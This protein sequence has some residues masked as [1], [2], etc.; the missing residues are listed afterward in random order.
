MEP[1]AAKPEPALMQD[2]SLVSLEA[3]LQQ[4]AA[5]EYDAL[6]GVKDKPTD[7]KPLR[8]FLS[9]SSPE[10]EICQH[11]YKALKARGHDPWFDKTS[12]R[13]GRDWRGAIAQGVQDSQ[14]V[15]ACLSEH[16]TRDDEDGHS[17]CLD[18]LAIAAGVKEGCI[19]TVLLGPE[20]VVRPPDLVSH[21]Q[22]LDMSQ[23]EEK[24]HAGADVFM[25]WF[26]TCMCELFRLIENPKS[27]EFAGQ[28][29]ALKEILQPACDSSQRRQ[30]ELLKNGVVGR[31]WLAEK[32]NAWLEDKNSSPVC[33]LHGGPG[34]GKS[35]FSAFYTHYYPR[36]V[37][38]FFCASGQTNFND[39]CQVLRTLAYLLACRL[40]DYRLALLQKL[41]SDADT[42]VGLQGDAL[43]DAVKP[44]REML[45]DCSA[46][47]LLD[48]LFRNV[49]PQTIDGG[50]PNMAILID[51]L[52]ECSNR[53]GNALAKVLSECFCYRRSDLWPRWLKILVVAREAQDVTQW[54]PDMGDHG[55]VQWLPLKEAS[56]ENL[57]DIRTF[58]VQE[59][60]G[61]F[62]KEPAW[63]QALAVLTER[64]GGY[65]L[66]AELMT[67]L[68][69]RTGSLG[70][71]DS[72]PTDLDNVFLYWFERIFPDIKMYRKDFQDVLGLLAVAPAPL[73]ET[74]LRDLFDWS[75]TALAQFFAPLEPLL[76]HGKNEFGDRTITF[77]H[78]YVG[79][80]LTELHKKSPP[81]HKYY[82]S[83]EDALRE[84]GTHFFGMVQDETRAPADYVLL[85]LPVILQQSPGTDRRGERAKKYRELARN[86][87]YLQQ[88]LNAAA[89][90]GCTTPFLALSFCETAYEIAHDGAADRSDFTSQLRLV[91]CLRTLAIDHLKLENVSTAFRLQN[92]AIDILD[93]LKTQSAVQKSNITMIQCKIADAYDDL[94]RMYMNQCRFGMAERTARKALVLS[95]HLMQK[96]QDIRLLS[97]ALETMAFIHHWCKDNHREYVVHLWEAALFLRFWMAMSRSENTTWLAFFQTLS[98][99]EKRDD[100]V[101]RYSDDGDYAWSI[102][103]IVYSDISTVKK[104]MEEVRPDPT[105]NSLPP[106]ARYKTDLI[107]P[108]SRGTKV[109]ADKLSVYL[110]RKKLQELDFARDDSPANRCA[111]A[112]TLQAIADTVCEQ[113][114]IENQETAENNRLMR[115]EELSAAYLMV[116]ET[117]EWRHLETLDKIMFGGESILS[118]YNRAYDLLCGIEPSVRENNPD[119]QEQF[120]TLC[121]SFSKKLP[122]EDLRRA[123]LAKAGQEAAEKLPPT[124]WHIDLRH[125]L[126]EIGQKV[127]FSPVLA[128]FAEHLQPWFGRE[129]DWSDCLSLL[130]EQCGD[131]LF[132]SVLM[133]DIL[134]TKNSLDGAKLKLSSFEATVCLWFAVTFQDIAWYQKNILPLLEFVLVASSPVPAQELW[135]LVRSRYTSDVQAI[136]IFA[137]EMLQLASILKRDREPGLTFT[138]TF[139]DKRIAEWLVST[140]AGGYQINKAQAKANLA[141]FFYGRY[142]QG[143]EKMTN[144]EILH[145]A[146]SL[147]HASDP[148]YY[149][150]LTQRVDWF[151][152]WMKIGINIPNFYP[153]DREKAVQI[154]QECR[155]TAEDALSLHPDLM[156]WK[157]EII[158]TNLIAAEKLRD[159]DTKQAFELYQRTMKTIESM[160]ELMEN[161][162]I[163]AQ[164]FTATTCDAMATILRKWSEDPE[165]IRKALALANRAL[166]IWDKLEKRDA[167]YEKNWLDTCKTICLILPRDDPR[168][169]Q[170]S[171]HGLELALDHYTTDSKGIY[172]TIKIFEGYLSESL[173]AAQETWQNPNSE[174]RS[175]Y[176]FKRAMEIWEKRLEESNQFA[177]WWLS[178]CENV[179]RLLPVQNPY[180]MRLCEQALAFAKRS[181]NN[182]SEKEKQKYIR[183]FEALS[184]GDACSIWPEE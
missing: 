151:H 152:R 127:V 77:Y 44:A 41:T 129:K 28:I 165:N 40:P 114:F 158:W 117:D 64:S 142:L 15:I 162:P 84:L 177:W 4:E 89:K 172:F 6:P 138:F 169:K 71:I 173:S 175:F 91:D 93:S 67:N 25:P 26:S 157:E 140:Q 16:S 176:L 65:F 51:G 45:A 145:L 116:S 147:K 5:Q 164:Y 99:F 143:P 78:P 141:D 146:E 22:W 170:L 163:Q 179:C 85:W 80:W 97:N 137:H 154:L 30:A 111:L 66:Y 125:W 32:V 7:F 75:D 53:E 108:R 50:R 100:V 130:C 184:R 23:W 110:S 55:A 39:P 24:L 98:D 126:A 124:H 109:A 17:V 156:I 54:L 49:L 123:V 13:A 11:I 42:I 120:V 46:S 149:R 12:L 3:R 92:E 2:L 82:Y 183:T 118:L 37:A 88:L 62:G 171:E 20:S 47:E 181:T 96:S 121:W 59:L 103:S 167:K 104:A 58:F 57:A 128:Y 29:H 144:Y 73:P 106:L 178:S 79:E 56:E 36:V 81:Y 87:H 112:A 132:R 35:A 139:R 9:Y 60:E 70:D 180:R 43:Q 52:D 34:V 119:L 115:H 153:K 168:R 159:D 83:R 101:D 160:P 150:A 95:T 74:V 135:Q 69:K 1:F 68:L 31:E 107:E 14:A 10:I 27:L 122:P 61:L 174:R 102:W 113:Q 19:H 90:Y 133:T 18:E 155:S 76:H 63:P 182:L 166:S 21:I 148:S 94:A 33:M 134:I 48:V 38:A 8:V 72:Y 136:G 105:N 131:D 161:D 86:G